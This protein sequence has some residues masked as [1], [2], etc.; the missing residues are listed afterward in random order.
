MTGY[1][2]ITTVRHARGSLPELAPEVD[3]ELLLALLAPPAPPEPPLAL[4]LAPADAAPLPVAEVA[5]PV[6][7]AC[8]SMRPVYNR[9]ASVRLHCELSCILR[10]RQVG[11]YC[12]SRGGGADSSSQLLQ[13]P[14]LQPH[15][16]L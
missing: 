4:P 5:V 14:C 8:F 10:S 2:L 7:A 3:A 6:L 1:A 11:R 12:V 16:K 13:A 15:R 9:T